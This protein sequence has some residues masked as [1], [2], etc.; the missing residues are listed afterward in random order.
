MMSLNRSGRVGA[1]SFKLVF[2]GSLLFLL[3]DTMI[4]FNKFHSDIPMAG[5]LIMITYIA[6]QYLIMRG[7]I[8]EK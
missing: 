8:L 7:L 3:S 2:V 6:A 1:M 5:F 4:A